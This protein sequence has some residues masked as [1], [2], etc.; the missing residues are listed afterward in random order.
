MQERK[1]PDS[2][3][4]L[5]FNNLA[6]ID[7]YKGV[8]LHFTIGRTAP[9]RLAAES[10]AAALTGKQPITVDDPNDFWFGPPVKRGIR[11]ADGSGIEVMG[12][13]HPDH[14]G[15]AARWQQTKLNRCK[16]MG[17]RVA[18]TATTKHHTSWCI[19]V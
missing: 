19:S 11:L 4:T 2:I 7:K 12:E 17:D 15:E 8:R 13:Q 6:G 16:Q 10:V 9:G 3:H 5:H 18:L 1:L 14:L